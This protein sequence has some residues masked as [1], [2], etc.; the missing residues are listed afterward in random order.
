[1]L[2]HLERTF[3][4]R[5][6]EFQATEAEIDKMDRTLH[7]IDLEEQELLC[8]LSRIREQRAALRTVRY[9]AVSTLAPVHRL[10]TE[11]LE[12]IFVL[13]TYGYAKIMQLFSL[14]LSA[15][16]VTIG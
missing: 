13:G 1:M 15:T 11:L 16:Q 14:C 5:S 7:Q 3:L 9:L 2:I 12:R 10:P 6:M 8:H 4:A